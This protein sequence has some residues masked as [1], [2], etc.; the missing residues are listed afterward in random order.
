MLN[1]LTELQKE[2]VI[3]LKDSK[4][5][6]ET[7]SKLKLDIE[8]LDD[9]EL[10][11]SHYSRKVESMPEPKLNV[12]LQAEHIRY[13]ENA[14]KLDKAKSD[15]NSKCTEISEQLEQLNSEVLNITK[16][17]VAK[18]VVFGFT[19]QEECSDLMRVT[20]K[21]M[22]SAS[23]VKEDTNENKNLN[24]PNKGVVEKEVSKCDKDEDENSVGDQTDLNNAKNGFDNR[25]K[26]KYA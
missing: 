4:S 6:V 18:N 16:A 15:Y 23:D 26:I 22:I 5:K 7:L 11:Y 21:R 24:L 9:L 19:M 25:V 14:K 2:G 20:L 3:L 1:W 8:L 17:I 13:S 12:E 10:K